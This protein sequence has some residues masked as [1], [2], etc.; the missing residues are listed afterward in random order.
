M[1]G[2][3]GTQTPMQALDNFL[4]EFGG[5]KPLFSGGV[6]IGHWSPAGGL[7]GWFDTSAQNVLGDLCTQNVTL[8]AGLT[9]AQMDPSTWTTVDD[10]LFPIKVQDYCLQ[11]AIVPNWMTQEQLNQY[12]QNAD[13][14][15]VP[16]GQSSIVL[17]LAIGGGLVLLS[18]IL[19]ARR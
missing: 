8:N 19:M 2:Y 17:P 6:Q 16:Q 13:G 5:V 1:S 4:A 7:V 11:K 10:N 14:S 15:I 9:A 3:G 12:Q 18:I